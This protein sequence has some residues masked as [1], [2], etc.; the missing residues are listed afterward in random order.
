MAGLVCER[1]AS[2]SR[3]ELATS[4]VRRGEVV[5]EPREPLSSPEIHSQMH[6][7]GPRRI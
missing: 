6:T 4:K 5:W 1:R 7:L 3:A 2:G